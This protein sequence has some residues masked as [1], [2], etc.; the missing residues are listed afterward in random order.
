[1][2]E[3]ARA[4]ENSADASS[5]GNPAAKALAISSFSGQMNLRVELS[6]DVDVAGM[7]RNMTGKDA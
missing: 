3:N 5:A 2:H 6:A 1:M 4:I 7:G